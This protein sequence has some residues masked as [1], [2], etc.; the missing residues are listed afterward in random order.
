[1]TYNIGIREEEVLTA[2]QKL[3]NAQEDLAAAY[4]G[5]P[6]N[7]TCAADPTATQELDDTLD[8]AM[9][10]L[11]K[12]TDGWQGYLATQADNIKA[13][14][15]DLS[16]LDENFAHELRV[17]TEWVEG[18][19]AAVVPVSSPV[20]GPGAAPGGAGGTGAAAPGAGTGPGVVSG[21]SGPGAAPGGAGGSG[22]SASSAG[23]E[24]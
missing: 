14:V 21:G 7:L 11:K 13:T 15:E 3:R 1:M 12:R 2:I 18:V 6:P 4:P 16:A 5:P 19:V 17:E 9:V 20:A 10:Q 22:S 8:W 23:G 24:G